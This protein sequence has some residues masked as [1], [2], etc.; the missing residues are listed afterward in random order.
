MSRRLNFPEKPEVRK[1][2][3]CTSLSGPAGA[4]DRHSSSRVQLSGYPTATVPAIQ[5]PFR[6]SSN[7]LG[8]EL[9]VT[10]PRRATVK[11]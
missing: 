2:T 9:H 5:S 10:V 11:G 7:A 1:R 4:R 3:S 6:L 8:G